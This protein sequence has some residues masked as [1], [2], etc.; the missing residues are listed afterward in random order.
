VFGTARATAIAFG[1]LALFFGFCAYYATQI[2]LW[3]DE[4]FSLQLAARSW[5]EMLAVPETHLRTY[6]LLLKEANAAIAPGCERIFLLRLFHALLFA[7]GLAF[8][9]TL[10]SR[11]A[12]PTVVLGALGLAVVLPPFIYYATNIRMYALLFLTAMGYFAAVARVLDRRQL[13]R[14]TAIALE[15]S[16]IALLASTYLA[17]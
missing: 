15:L 4:A 10:A 11:L 7:G 9:C 8:G 12:K 16:A 6:Y 14:S 3:G 1:L 2:S 17:T 13:T 5:S